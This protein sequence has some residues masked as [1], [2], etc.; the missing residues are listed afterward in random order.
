MGQDKQAVRRAL[1]LAARYKQHVPRDDAF[2]PV[3]RRAHMCRAPRVPVLLHQLRHIALCGRELSSDDVIWLR[4]VPA[5]ARQL[6]CVDLR[7]ARGGID[8]ALVCELL[9]VES[10]RA[11]CVVD[12]NSTLIGAVRASIANDDATIRD[13]L[14]DC[15][16]V[17]ECASAT[18]AAAHARYFA[19]VSAAYET[20][21]RS[22]EDEALL[23]DDA[24]GADERIDDDNGDDDA[25]LE[26]YY[27]E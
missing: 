22:V 25:V 26:D 21:A 3:S 4:A 24:D 23:I 12:V 13:K 6:Q 18:S 10:M 17:R 19:Y 5:C 7:G 8:A 15:K 16:T 11:V 20:L 9:R 2:R 1:A 27:Y 14:I